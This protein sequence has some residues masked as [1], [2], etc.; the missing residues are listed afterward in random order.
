MSL[1][2]LA[3]LLV[4]GASHA[5]RDV[6]IAAAAGS[7]IP[8]LVL[9]AVGQ[10]AGAGAPFSVARSDVV[11]VPERLDLVGF[12]TE[13][14]R[15][16][17][18]ILHP[19]WHAKA[20]LEDRLFTW[21][22][23][24]SAGRAVAR[25]ESRPVY[26][27]R[28]A[29]D[30]PAGTLIDDRY[31]LSLPGGLSANTYDLVLQT[32]AIDQSNAGTIPPVVVGQVTLDANPGPAPETHE[33]IARFAD[34]IELG[35]GTLSINDRPVNLSSG[36][37]IVAHA[38]DQLHLD[39]PWRPLRGLYG[40]VKSYAHLVN[41]GA[42]VAKSDQTPGTS[43]T[44]VSLWNLD[45][46][47]HDVH[48]LTVATELTG[49]VYEMI[50]GLYRIKALNDP[51]LE[52]WPMTTTDYPRRSETIVLFRVKVLGP[53]EIN[54]AR[55]LARFGGFAD[56]IGVEVVPGAAPPRPGATVI[57]RLTYRAHGGAPA[58]LTQ[59]IHL[60][61]AAGLIGQID[62]P[63]LGNR[64]PTSSWQPGEIIHEELTFTVQADAQSGP[65][66]VILG[67]YDPANGERV[68]AA[69]PDGTQTQ[70]RSVLLGA[71]EI[72]P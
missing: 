28:R 47:S 50:V 32:T 39:L 6:W 70:D 68:V 13:Q 15:A 22:L 63:P 49:G 52:I 40:S 53:P 65:A 20:P 44:P 23:Q 33:P 54:R 60:V 8:L 17:V 4:W 31:Q 59:F 58:D 57:V 41:G 10:I 34:R 55:P 2:T 72:A 45:R 21:L 24:D 66:Q 26:G 3:G 18:L 7:L 67:F 5:R 46:W 1:A 27:S 12:G 25:I 29:T 9:G 38:G 61:N 11:V 16:D 43:Y 56:L 14:P 35:Q 62:A 37:W 36:P 71:L 48:T 51:N 69:L 64:N 30:W 19:Y 42:S